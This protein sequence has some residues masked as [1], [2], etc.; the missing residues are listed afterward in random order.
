M[1]RRYALSAVVLLALPLIFLIVQSTV[2]RLLPDGLA[3][4]AT[5]ACKPPLDPASAAGIACRLPT[6]SALAPDF[7]WAAPDAELPAIVADDVQARHVFVIPLALLVV[8][9]LPVTAVAALGLTRLGGGR[10]LAVAG[11]VAVGAGGFGYVFTDTHPLRLFLVEFLL[12]RAAEDATYPYLS[13]ATWTAMKTA[14]DW[15]TVFT[16]AATAFL[17]MLAARLAILADAAELTTSALVRRGQWLRAVVISGSIFLALTVAAAYGL[18]HWSSALVAEA[19][20]PAIESLASSAMVYW[21]MM[22]SL[23]MSL[24]AAPTIAAL[25]IDLARFADAETVD[26]AAIYKATGLNLDLTRA[27]SLAL[28]VAAPALTGPALDILKQLGSF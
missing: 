25:R 16:M 21:G 14:L 22:W 5:P 1:I 11:A 4:V 18:L 10:W 6:L 3:S 23:G 19:A 7:A 28:A 24:L 26:G 20:R 2:E 15:T 13:V 17:F 8:L 27:A 12:R 9:A